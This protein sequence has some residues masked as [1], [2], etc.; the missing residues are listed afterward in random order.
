[1]QAQRE[2][3]CRGDGGVCDVIVGGADSAGGY[4]EAV[5]GREA[6]DSGYDIGNGVGDGFDALKGDSEGEEVLCEEGGVCVDDLA[7]EDLVADD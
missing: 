3:V 2:V 4:D 6:A 5:G 1:M 7:V